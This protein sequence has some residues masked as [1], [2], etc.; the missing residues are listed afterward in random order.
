MMSMR[1]FKFGPQPALDKAIEAQ[2]VCEEAVRQ[3]KAA[4]AQE[5]AKLRQLQDEVLRAEQRVKAAHD[6]LVS[7][8]RKTSEPG[9]LAQANRH[10]DGLRAKVLMQ[11]EAVEKQKERVAWAADKVELRK[12]E[13]AEAMAA[14]EALEKLKEK[15]RLEH[16]AA[17]LKAEEAKRDDEAIQLWNNQRE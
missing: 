7:P 17:L 4:L 1:Q 16:Q 9:E 12:R 14:V 10:L 3:A 15:R 5:R 8:V 13:L 6:N 2:R 11:R